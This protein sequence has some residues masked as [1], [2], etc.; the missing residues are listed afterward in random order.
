[1]ALEIN[2]WFALLGFCYSTSFMFW[3]YQSHYS[4][5]HGKGAI[6]GSPLHWESVCAPALRGAWF[7]ARDCVTLPQWRRASPKLKH[8]SGEPGPVRVTSIPPLQRKRV[9]RHYSWL[10]GG[11]WTPP[12]ILLGRY[13]V[14]EDNLIV[15]IQSVWKRAKGHDLGR[16]ID[17]VIVVNQSQTVQVNDNRLNHCLG[18]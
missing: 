5:A 17:G 8:R 11:S 18:L 16:W 2:H 7:Q 14:S 9:D 13:F 4:G 10:W 3:F 12:H 1:M 15:C 6:Y